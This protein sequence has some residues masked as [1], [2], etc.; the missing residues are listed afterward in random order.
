MSVSL[1]EETG[2]PGGKHRP[3]ASNLQRVSVVYSG[4]S[5]FMTS[6]LLYTVYVIRSVIRYRS[7]P[8]LINQVLYPSYVTKCVFRSWGGGLIGQ[9]KAGLRKYVLL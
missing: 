4:W 3:T 1:V 2:V 6:G 7:R 5:L 8:D 9:L